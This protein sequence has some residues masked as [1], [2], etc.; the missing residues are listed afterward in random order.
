M[1]KKK[2]RPDPNNVRANL[3]FYYRQYCLTEP[4]DRNLVL[5]EMFHGQNVSDSGP[6]FARAIEACYP[7]RFRIYFTSE[8]VP[9]HTQQLA[10]MGIRAE[11]VD[12]GTYEYA[13]ILAVAGFIFA[14]AGVPIFF[15]KRPGQVYMQT[16]HGTPLKTLGK[17]MRLGIDTLYQAQH[18]FLQADYLTQPNEFTK[19]IIMNDYNLE[20]LYTGKVVMAGYPRNSVFLRP[21]QGEALRRARGLED[22]HVFIYMPTWRGTSWNDKIV[23]DYAEAVRLIFE[24]LDGYLTDD[25]IFYVRFHPILRDSVKLESYRHILPFPKDV[26]PYEFIS[27]SDVLVTD[28]SSIFFDFS[29]TKKP[30]ILFTYDLDEYLRDRGMYFDIHTLPFRMVST[31]AELGECLRDRTYVNDT[32][33]DTEYYKTFFKYDSA[34]IAQKL[35]RLAV[36][37]DEGGLEIHDYSANKERQVTVLKPADYKDVQ[38]LDTIARKADENTVVWFYAGWFKDRQSELLYDKYNDSFDY[39]ITKNAVPVT[40]EEFDKLQEEPVDE[41]FAEEIWKRDLERTLPGLNVVRTLTDFGF[42]DVGYYAEKAAVVPGSFRQ[43][44]VHSSGELTV[45]FDCGALTPSSVLLMNGSY[46]IFWKRPLTPEE[47]EDGCFTLDIRQMLED[48]T[49]YR[50]ETPYI[51][52]TCLDGEG[53]EV[54]VLLKDAGMEDG[55]REMNGVRYYQG[56][57]VTA[58]LP[59]D[60]GRINL[61]KIVK[62]PFEDIRASQKTYNW[63]KKPKE[64]LLLP[65]ADNNTDGYLRLEINTGVSI[66]ALQ[67][68]RFSCTGSAL[69]IIADAPGLTPDHVLKARLIYRSQIEDIAIPLRMTVKPGKDGSRLTVYLEKDAL[70]GIKP[71]YWDL[72]VTV[73]LIGCDVSTRLDLSDKKLHRLLRLL[74]IQLK[75]GDGNIVFP[76]VGGKKALAFCVRP[77]T[78]Y[79][80]MRTRVKELAAKVI[81]KVFRSQLDRRNILLIYEKFS[82]TAQDNSYYFFKYCM[83][84]LTPEENENIFYV[85]DKKSEDYPK[86][87]MYGKHV[88][89]F[90][91]FRHMLCMLAARF[92]ISTDTKSHLYVWRSKPSF[93]YDTARRRKNQVFLQHGVTALK[94]VHNLFGKSGSSPMSFFVTTSQ[95]EQDIIVGNFGYARTEAPILGF[96]RWDVLTDKSDPGNKSILLMPTWRAWLEDSDDETFVKSDYYKHYTSLLLSERLKDM[97]EKYDARIVLC[98]HP[99]FAD[100]LD[101]FRDKLGD[102][103]TMSSS[104]EVPVNEQIMRCSALITD[105]SSVCWDTLYL[106]KPVI[107]YQFD[108][109]RYMEAHGSYIDMRTDLPGDRAEEENELLSH[110]ERC[111]ANDCHLSEENEKKSDAYFAYRDQNNCRRTYDFIKG[112]L[113]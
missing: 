70:P 91:S 60:Y 26:E 5:I 11:L 49:L 46:C 63:D 9:L 40:Y 104:K 69:K 6:E 106:R 94:R 87:A 15:S 105:Y 30:V 48:L 74:N 83:D 50:G 58:D 24:E 14:N 81:S 52:L 38:R 85:I 51:G 4:V 56:T 22:K 1:A 43:V 36:E 20:R 86:V 2:K 33:E 41:A 29:L 84:E 89:P 42:C 19:N 31:A 90:M 111:L 17:K 55:F 92:V 7:G 16:W 28:Y 18:G 39:I 3:R 54:L 80:N 79:D 25:D 78:Q 47:K 95:V 102:R 57:G 62:S 45:G 59:V 75:L 96:T 53:K 108:Y 34:D 27:C 35:V 37:G 10:D 8:N 64:L 73:S 13:R 71:V 98:L 113:Q 66:N 23:S 88:L 110:I 44:S 68:K 61:K 101:T 109:D 107:F 67:V 99:K 97:L 112:Q 77:I 76:Y 100:H 103:I 12:V 93:V 21:E 82:A 72:E 32:Y 65:K